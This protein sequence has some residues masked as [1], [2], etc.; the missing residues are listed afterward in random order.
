MTLSMS[1]RSP[2]TPPYDDDYNQNPVGLVE[3]SLKQRPTSVSQPVPAM[4][5]SPP[6]TPRSSRPKKLSM[7]M[8]SNSGLSFHV[9]EDAL[10]QYT[11][12]N[13]DG[14]PRS[15]TFGAGI[16]SSL[17]SVSTSFRRNFGPTVAE[18]QPEP[19]PIPDF[20]GREL[21]QMIL[22]NPAAS[23]R[24]LQF[25]QRSGCGPDVEFLLRIQE[26]S[27]A[28][29][30]FGKQASTV[31]TPRDLPPTTSKSLNADMKQL[32][33]TV[34]PG[35][36]MLFNESTRCVEK[37]LARDLYPA[38]VKQQLANCTSAS[39][40][41]ARGGPAF[42]GLAK[43]F[44]LVDALTPDQPII[45]ASDA[46]VS[47]TGYPR[48]EAL[49]RNCRFMQG[50]LTDKSTVHRVRDS[51]SRQEESLELVLNYRRDGTPYW[52]L[53]FTCPLL[54]SA[55]KLRYYLGGQV[56]VSNDAGDHQDLIRVLN[57][58]PAPE[59]AKS[60]TAGRESRASRRISHAGSHERKHERKHERRRSLR[61]H[62][63]LHNRG[64]M[65]SL[66]QPFRK[67]AAQNAENQ[68]NPLPSPGDGLGLCAQGPPSGPGSEEQLSVSSQVDTVYPA[69]SR[70]IIVQNTECLPGF[71]PR[72]S[73]LPADPARRKV[74]PLSV[75]FCSAA[76]LEAL[77][78]RHLAESIAHRDI[79][80]VLSDQADSP[81]V[82]KG[83]KNTV[84]EQVVRD[85]RSVTL[86]IALGGG[87]LGRKGSLMGF[88]GGRSSK[89]DC[90]TSSRRHGRPSSR[91]GFSGLVGDVGKADK[92]I[93]HWTPLKN[94]EEKVEWIVVIM[95]P[96]W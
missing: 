74:A 11:D 76:A 96:V 16:W 46:F 2:V 4:T 43:S 7:K 32:T 6:P 3:P 54:D 70:L 45:A 53:L 29:A 55:G 87:Y 9:N 12:Y 58:E 66:F 89:D 15:P 75:A 84:R 73:S 68:E 35:L 52:N 82:T 47:V 17:D 44:C 13:P 34:L 27:K 21:F 92:F 71:P 19:W 26:Y 63:G 20:L 38:F 48:F 1:R 72:S 83:F 39:M 8:R 30:Q 25:A 51:V 64:P 67:H 56:N 86:D 62:D 36:E 23:Q 41:G 5:L 40:S 10:R 60:E 94:A 57:S 69:Y 91:S 79:F 42:P 49:S 65:K 14:S 80:A 95:T 81:S 37:R 77:G 33:G 59:D 22:G 90:D 85:G 78:I 24:L 31:P 50:S 93:S 88:G 28:L 61:N 18:A